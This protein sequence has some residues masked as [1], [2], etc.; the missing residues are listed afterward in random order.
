[1]TTDDKFNKFSGVVNEVLDKIA[2]TK[3][4]RISPKRRY[5]EPWMTR[6]LE[7]SSQI[8]M[9]LYKKTLSADHTAENIE[10]YKAQQ[11]AYNKLKRKFKYNY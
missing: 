8:K 4:V 2:P 5:V 3:M 11:N 1:M 7:K 6:G 10:R 9:K